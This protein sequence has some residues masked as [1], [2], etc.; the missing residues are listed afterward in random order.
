MNRTAL[1]IAGL[2][3]VGLL[4]TAAFVRRSN[5]R[6]LTFVDHEVIPLITPVI[7][8]RVAETVLSA[9]EKMSGEN[10]TIIIHTQGGCVASCVMIAKAV[11]QFR[12]SHAVVPY[13]AI[14]GGTMIALSASNLSMGRNAALSAVDPIVMGQRAKNIEDGENVS[15]HALG[16]LAREYHLAV[17]AFLRET[18]ARRLERSSPK[19]LDAAVSVFMGE[20]RPHEW[21]ISS[22]QV[23][24]LG[25]AVSPTEPHWAPIVDEVRRRWW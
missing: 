20:D 2:A 4:G 8:L 13:M 11:A 16:A 10:L 9:M 6:A 19:E 25:I 18:L 24:E 21:P 7:D 14:S 15:E 1:T 12:T 5:R 23:S 22:T 3:G 17:G